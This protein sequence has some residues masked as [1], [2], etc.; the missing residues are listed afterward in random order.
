MRVDEG[1]L[2]VGVAEELLGQDTLWSASP[3]LFAYWGRARLR[4]A[5]GDLA[6]ALVDL[7][8]GEIQTRRWVG[9][10][11]ASTTRQTAA[12]EELA[13]SGGRPPR[14]C[15]LPSHPRNSGRD[16]RGTG[17]RPAAQ[18]EDATRRGMPVKAVGVP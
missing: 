8:V 5:S 6:G 15:R 4:E 1:R 9:G 11:A 7:R 17:V 16:R 10:D 18:S 13:A 12:Q 14:R 3:A 2:D